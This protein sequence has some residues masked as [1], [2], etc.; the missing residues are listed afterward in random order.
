MADRLG[1]LRKR[2]G[3][4]LWPVPCVLVPGMFGTRP[5]GADQVDWSRAPDVGAYL[6][7]IVAAAAMAAHRRRPEVTLLVAGAAVVTYLLVGYPFGPILVALPLAAFG[8]AHAWPVRRAVTWNAA[9][10]LAAITAGGVRFGAEVFS[11][12]ALEHLAGAGATVL[13]IAAP[14]AIG[15]ALRIRQESEAGLRAAHARRAVSEERLRMAQELHDSVGHG[16]AVIAMQAGVALHVLD[17]EP[18]KVRASLEAIRDASRQSLDSLRAELQVLR[19]PDAGTDGSAAPRRPASG[20]GDLAVLAERVRAGGLAVEIDVQVA[21][22]PAEIDQGVHHIVQESLTN[23]L[24]HGAA[25]H[26]SVRVWIELGAVHVDVSDDGTAASTGEPSS[27]MGISGMRSRA[28]K[29]NGELSAGPAP[30]GGFTV[31]ARLPL[32]PGSLGET[33][34]KARTTRGASDAQPD[35][36][37]GEVTGSP[38]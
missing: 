30:N 5:A 37:P 35:A 15:A 36:E 17:R 32:P 4:D 23:T 13:V 22:L 33:A 2:W 18:G 26:A 14:T 11:G 6:L 38:P 29:L 27:G 16:L 12:D 10:C 31:R 3:R 28:A 34:T 20:V 9:L 7:V 21:E 1:D 19:S 8:V 25:R 24:R